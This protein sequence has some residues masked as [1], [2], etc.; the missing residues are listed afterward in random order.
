MSDYRT[1]RNIIS[2]SLNALGYLDEARQAMAGVLEPFFLN[3]THFPSQRLAE[4]A[5]EMCVEHHPNVVFSIREYGA[6][7]FLTSS[8]RINN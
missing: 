1:A 6:G 7:V 4:C 3:V 5:I 2:T 8:R